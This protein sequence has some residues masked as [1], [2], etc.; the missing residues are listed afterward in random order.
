MEE[1]YDNWVQGPLNCN[2]EFWS[3]DPFMLK[4]VLKFINYDDDYD[5]DVD[6]G[7]TQLQTL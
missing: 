4:I 6:N 7:P 3:I 1:A 2:T 5:V